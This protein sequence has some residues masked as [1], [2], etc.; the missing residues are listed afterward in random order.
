MT[1]LKALGALQ[2]CWGDFQCTL[3]PQDPLSLF[4]VAPSLGPLTERATMPA[5]DGK[6]PDEEDIFPTQ[7]E[8]SQAI[9]RAKEIT[10]R[11]NALIERDLFA[12]SEMRD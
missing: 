3:S 9:E 7:T 1:K 8:A 12:A 6:P 10:R 11:K 4:D 2:I 5:S